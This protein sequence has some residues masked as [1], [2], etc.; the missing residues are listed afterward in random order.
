MSSFPCAVPRIFS[1]STAPGTAYEYSNYGFAILGQ[2]VERVAKR[3]YS[4]FVRDNILLP[5][6]M[7]S[8]TRTRAGRWR[9]VNSHI[10]GG[11]VDL[12]QWWLRDIYEP[13]R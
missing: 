5:L 13:D 12:V 9:N 6:G 4:D 1:I 10:R 8:T 7:K 2:I 3:P 11:G